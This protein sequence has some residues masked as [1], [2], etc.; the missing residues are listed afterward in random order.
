[1]TPGDNERMMHPPPPEEEA[2]TDGSPVG[3]GLTFWEQ[4]ELFSEPMEAMLQ[5][6]IAAGDRVVITLDG[7]LIICDP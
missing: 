1:M 6:R 4:L 5:R 2:P 7:D 3:G